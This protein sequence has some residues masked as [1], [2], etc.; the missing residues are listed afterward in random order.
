MSKFKAGDLALVIGDSLNAGRCVE[1]V[2]HVV[3]PADVKVNEGR[4][5]I[6]IPEGGQEWVVKADRLEGT[7][8]ISG[9]TVFVGEL[10]YSE[11]HLIPLR[12]DFTPEEMREMEKDHA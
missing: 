1:L 3:G 5:W 7:L 4:N 10:T 12:G 8:T 11:K 2:R 9:K 6:R